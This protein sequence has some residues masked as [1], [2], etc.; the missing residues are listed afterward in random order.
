ML[1]DIEWGEF[2]KDMSL[3]SSI[4]TRL[5]CKEHQSVKKFFYWCGADYIQPW[6]QC[7]PHLVYED[8]LMN[9]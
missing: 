8:V 5:T 4:P 3:K 2:D 1:L 7:S 6:Q 9:M